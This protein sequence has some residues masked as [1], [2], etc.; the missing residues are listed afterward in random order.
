[1]DNL[2]TGLF[3][4]TSSTSLISIG[5]FFICIMAALLAGLIIA[6]SYKIRNKT[7]QNF[8]TTLALMPA[9]VCVIILMVNGNIGTGVAVTG[10]FSL[11]R[12]R[13]VA[14]SS[15]DLGAIFLAMGTGLIIGMGYIGFAFVFAII[16]SIMQIIYANIGMGK[17]D[18]VDRTMRIAIPED[19]DYTGV[20]EDLFEKYTISNQLTNVKTTDMGSL[21]RLTYNISLKDAKLEKEL[22]DNLRCRNGNLEISISKQEMSSEL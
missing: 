3:E 17:R 7:T 11:I 2:F 9:M 1:M 22:I 10:A 13:S 21:F 20:F 18:D 5:K 14:G 4:T 12:F 6:L 15:S 19:L 8:V 16:I